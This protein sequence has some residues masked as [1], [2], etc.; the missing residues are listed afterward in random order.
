MRMNTREMIFAEFERRLASDSDSEFA[1]C[2]EQIHLITR[3]RLE[4]LLETD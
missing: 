2:I 1:A 3:L 4:A